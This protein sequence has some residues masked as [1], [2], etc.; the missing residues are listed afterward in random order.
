MPFA[1]FSHPTRYVLV[2][3]ATGGVEVWDEGWWPYINRVAV[4]EWMGQGRLISDDVVF[5]NVPPEDVP[6]VSAGEGYPRSAAVATGPILVGY[7]PTVVEP[8]RSSLGGGEAV[9]PMN[10]VSAGQSD[11][12]T[13]DDMANSTGFSSDTSSPQYQPRGDTQQD[14]EDA[15]QRAI[16]GGANDIFLY[17]T[18]H[19][20]RTLDGESYINYRGARITAT[21]FGEMLQKFQGVKFKVVIDACYSGGFTAILD[22][23]GMTQIVITSA[24]ADEVSYGDWDP[25]SDPNGDTD[26]GGEFSSGL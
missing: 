21:K 12:D 11:V 1:K 22:A 17:Y 16:D 15:I 9:V 8:G 23:T 7:A 2:D 6:P 14:I 3:V 4:E 13:P 25:R 10:G 24:A 26:K 20:G 18:G 5:S 19:G